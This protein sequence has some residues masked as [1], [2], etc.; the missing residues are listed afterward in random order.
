MQS[1]RNKLLTA[2]LATLL[3]LTYSD[4][5]LARSKK[6]GSSGDASVMGIQRDASGTPII[7]K[8]FRSSRADTKRAAVARSGRQAYRSV[9]IPRGSSTSIPS[10][11]GTT[12]GQAVQPYNP[13]RITTFSDRVSN[14]IQSYPLQKGLGNNPTDQQMYIRQNSN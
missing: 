1:Q 2:A 14:S 6:A 4:A 7:M 3:I 12:T 8:G 13:P 11:A 9:R 10:T 5:G